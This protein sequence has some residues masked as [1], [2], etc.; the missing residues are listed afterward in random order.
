MIAGL[1]Q[2]KV[3]MYDQESGGHLVWLQECT[4]LTGESP[5]TVHDSP[6]NT[7]RTDVF[8]PVRLSLWGRKAPKL[9]SSS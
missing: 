1:C 7:L 4:A 2:E 8:S 6:H 9:K 5:V 3:A